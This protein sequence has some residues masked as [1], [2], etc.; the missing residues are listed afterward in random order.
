MVIPNYLAIR[1][2]ELMAISLATR[3]M[4]F[5]NSRFA[6]IVKF[7]I[8]AQ[9]FLSLFPF[10]SLSL[11]ASSPLPNN[12]NFF[13]YRSLWPP[14]LERKRKFS[15]SSLCFSVF[16]YQV[17]PFPSLHYKFLLRVYLLQLS[18]KWNCI[19]KIYRS[20]KGRVSHSQLFTRI[21]QITFYFIFFIATMIQ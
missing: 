8:G 3:E 2:L 13:R 16:R 11:V 7:P 10:S 19:Q 17:L 20:E 14:H 5:F 18:N 4:E 6:D 21:S 15:I 12:T 1:I 9:I